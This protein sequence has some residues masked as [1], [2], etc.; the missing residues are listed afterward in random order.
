MIKKA[1]CMKVY[2]DKQEE[3]QKRHEELW[4]EM[5]E[6]LKLSMAQSAIRS[7]WSQR[8]V[9]YLLI[10][11]SLTKSAGLKSARDSN[12]PKMVAPHGRYHG[13]K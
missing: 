11:K 1:F 12:Q 7:F 13:N 2:P 6:M 8:R 10:W 3:Y 4:P 5:R 9:H